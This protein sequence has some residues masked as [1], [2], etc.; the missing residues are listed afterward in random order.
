MSEEKKLRM[1][2]QVAVDWWRAEF[3]KMLGFYNQREM[4]VDLLRWLNSATECDAS[5]P[6]G[7]FLTDAYDKRMKEREKVKSVLSADISKLIGD[8]SS[9]DATDKFSGPLSI[10]AILCIVNE[11]ISKRGVKGLAERKGNCAGM[12]AGDDDLKSLIAFKGPVIFIGR[13]GSAGSVGS[14]GGRTNCCIG[15]SDGRAHIED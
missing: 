8:S 3:P 15:G 9:L 13:V 1:A 7:F 2:K 10:D 14:S 11:L 4:I 12:N 5:D 6:L